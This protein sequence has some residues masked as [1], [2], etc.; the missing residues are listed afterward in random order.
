MAKSQGESSGTGS[1]NSATFDERPNT[2]NTRNQGPDRAGSSSGSVKK[3]TKE[4][5]KTGKIS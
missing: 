2:S 4:S 1:K 3:V 5:R